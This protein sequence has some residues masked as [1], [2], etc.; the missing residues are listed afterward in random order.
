MRARFKDMLGAAV[1]DRFREAGMG[2][3]EA[4]REIGQSLLGKGIDREVP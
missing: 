1:R 2:F 4:I 3:D